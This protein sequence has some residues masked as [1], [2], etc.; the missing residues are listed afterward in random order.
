MLRT[1]AWK[2]GSNLPTKKNP[3][4]Q[5]QPH[6]KNPVCSKQHEPPHVAPIFSPT[7]THQK[8]QTPLNQKRGETVGIHK[9]EHA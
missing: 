8:T 4:D 7:T 9:P 2:N 1:V 5:V 3:P 6:L